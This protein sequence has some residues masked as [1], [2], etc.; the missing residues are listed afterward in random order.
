MRLFDERS[1]VSARAVIVACIA[2]LAVSCASSPAPR[3]AEN[4][5]GQPLFAIQ[6]NMWM[7]L[8]HF[9]RVVAR[10]DPAPAKL[11]ADE[12]AIWDEAIATYKAKYANRDL[13]RDEGMLAI[14][15]TLRTIPSDQ[16]LPEIPGEPD[17]KEL[18]ERVAPVYRTH[19]WPAHDA[20]NRSWIA[21][22]Q[23]L[24]ARYG[25][26]LS[27]DLAA[28]YGE[29]WPSE[30]IPI[31]VSIS[32][33]PVGAYT[34]YPPHTTITS[35]DPTYYGLA[36]LEM[37]FHESSHQWGRRLDVAIRNAAEARKKEV[38]PQLWHA[39]LFYNSGELTRRALVADGVGWYRDYAAQHDIYT[40]L[41]GTGCRERV[42][43]HWKPHLDGNVS[44]EAALENLVADWP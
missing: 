44:I 31:D 13:L 15:N 1:G 41:C 26:R 14:K 38:P 30:P 12:Q 43:K 4:P 8:H 6:S 36:S 22:A 9:L 24:V 7:N 35:V 37:L 2:L 40:S 39:V 25:E 21:T 28:S 34:S 11:N 20:I 29:S 27:R 32:A 5:S 10:G 23:T 19:W 17:L 16:P 18:L 33:G 42:A 3:R